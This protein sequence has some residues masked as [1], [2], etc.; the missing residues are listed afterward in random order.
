MGHRTQPTRE[1]SQLTP[2]EA[3]AL[4]ELNSN[5]LWAVV[6]RKVEAELEVLTNRLVNSSAV[7]EIHA[8]QGGVRALKALIAWVE[9]QHITRQTKEETDV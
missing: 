6:H 3:Q 4:R 1:P 8:C 2:E 5:P 7:A 9:Q